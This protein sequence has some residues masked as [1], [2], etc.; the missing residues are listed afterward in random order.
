MIY[1]EAINGVIKLA[2]ADDV[3]EIEEIDEV[4]EIEEVK[5]A[6]EA[7]GVQPGADESISDNPVG[8]KIYFLYPHSVIQDEMVKTMVNMEFEIY[9]VRDHD[10]L[11]DIIE[12]EQEGVVFINIDQTL[13]DEGWKRYVKGIMDNPKTAQVKVGIL[14]YN[15]EEGLAQYY[16]MEL[17]VPCGFVQLKLGLV[18]STKIL[19][20][21]LEANEVRGRRKYVRAKCLDIKQVSFNVKVKSNYE[22]G[23]IQD[24][25]TAGMACFFDNK[26][27]KIDVG[28]YFEDIQLKLK[29]TICKVG[30]TVIGF[31]E[32][33]ENLLVVMFDK[34]KDDIKEKIRTFVFNALQISLQERLKK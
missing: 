1:S 9:L 12:E 28:Y 11:L 22:N 2:E 20:Q 16:L 13:D 34:M 8:K 15:Q 6:E 19:L 14:T 31:R 10:K 29:G 30:G 25:S 3:E 17:M 32:D 24:I 7:G 18:E 5:E 23:S 4:E 33:Q 27:V 26:N 21:V